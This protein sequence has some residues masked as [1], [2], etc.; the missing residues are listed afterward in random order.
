MTDTDYKWRSRSPQRAVVKQREA[1]RLREVEGLT[2]Q[3]VAERLGYASKAS[4]KKA[5]D[6]AVS[7]GGLLDLTDDEWRQLQ[8]HRLERL[9]AIAAK[10]AES[11]QDLGALRE[12]SRFHDRIVRLKALELVPVG[13]TSRGDDPE[14]EQDTATVVSAKRVSELRERRARDA[15]QRAGS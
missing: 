3:E 15:A 14:H 9:Y 2:F 13:P 11:E 7:D 6:K 10:K 4:A 1:R 8:L 12:A 5:Y